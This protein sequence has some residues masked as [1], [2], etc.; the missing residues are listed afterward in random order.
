MNVLVTGI[1]GF[2]GTQIAKDCVSRKINCVGISHSE[3]RDKKFQ[4]NV[5]GVK[6]YCLD[7]STDYS[8]L[9]KVIRE[10]NITHIIHCA[11]MKHI[12]LCESNP[13]KTIKTN[14]IGS[15]NLIEIANDLEITNIVAVSTDKAISPTSV[16]GS[17]KLLME[18]AMLEN[19]YSLIQGVNFFFS[20]GSVLDIWE[21]KRINSEPIGVNVNNPS[22]YFIM[23]TEMSKTILDNIDSSGIISVD[24]CFNVKLQDLSDAFCSYH[25]Y[26]NT[27]DYNPISVEKNDEEIPE[28]V[29]IVSA[30]TD[31]LKVKLEE[32]YS[33]N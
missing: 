17:S 29:K 23:V 24:E 12:G 15:L 1:T 13:T 2:L 11:A 25:D 3:T 7:I 16:Y 27:V 19:G 28:N 10:N 26:N 31:F 6:T 8:S 5:P 30:D 20:T 14:V 33:G 9:R 18:K 4:E 32:Y 21:T 22:R